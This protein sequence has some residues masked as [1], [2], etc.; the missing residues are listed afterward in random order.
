MERRPRAFWVALVEEVERGE[1]AAVVARRHGV[2]SVTLRGWR[3]KLGRE[4]MA[5]GPRLL[6][7]V[8]TRDVSRPIAAGQIDVAVRGLVLR[9]AVGTDIAYAADLVRALEPC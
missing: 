9:V 1:A 6:P 2:P 8:V 4:A 7:V 3:A 5:R